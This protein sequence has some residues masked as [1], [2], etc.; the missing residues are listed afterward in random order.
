MLEELRIS[1][2]MQEMGTRY[3]VS[4]QRLE[5]AWDERLVENGVRVRVR[6]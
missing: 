4:V 3:P 6:A 5:R 2:F 1:L